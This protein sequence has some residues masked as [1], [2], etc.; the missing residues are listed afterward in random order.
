MSECQFDEEEE[1]AAAWS[2]PDWPAWGKEPLAVVLGDGPIA[3][4][5]EA[6]GWATV[7]DLGE[8]VW[9]GLNDLGDLTDEMSC[10]PPLT[11]EETNSLR[12]RLIAWT[13]SQ[14]PELVLAWP[15][16]WIDD[17][18]PVLTVYLAKASGEGG[19]RV[20]LH[21]TD[22]A[23]A[24]KFAWSRFGRRAV[25]WVLTLED[26]GEDFDPNVESYVVRRQAER[27]EAR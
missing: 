5:L 10:D 4:K 11:A 8:W 3:A 6:N 15:S 1:K 2:D 12:A 20:R 25:A 16:A 26:A 23:A 9:E 27:S 19:E 7:G 14:G 22:I 17:R 18:L 21:A 13:E 24:Q